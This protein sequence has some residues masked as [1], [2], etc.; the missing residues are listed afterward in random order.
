VSIEALDNYDTVENEHEHLSELVGG[1]LDKLSPDE[2]MPMTRVIFVVAHTW[3]VI[4]RMMR[5]SAFTAL[6]AART[7]DHMDLF[8]IYVPDLVEKMNALAAAVSKTSGTTKP[9]TV[10]ALRATAAAET[11]KIRN[12]LKAYSKGITVPFFY[13]TLERFTEDL[14]K[15]ND[16][17]AHVYSQIPAAITEL[18]LPDDARS[19]MVQLAVCKSKLSWTDFMRTGL[20]E[21]VKDKPDIEELP[22]VYVAGLQHQF[23]RLVDEGFD[24]TVAY[25]TALEFVKV[26]Y[27]N[28]DFY[29]W[30]ETLDIKLHSA[31]GG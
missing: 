12:L 15:V 8:K 14:I 2:A 21:L 3:D 22:A 29:D 27:R 26:K 13:K 9:E 16:M 20:L 28:L 31:V 11:R 5:K 17:L 10:R 4:S 6:A 7:T 19:N 23:K 30:F 25:N 1:Y 18:P 24:D